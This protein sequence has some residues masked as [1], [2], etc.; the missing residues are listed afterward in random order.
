MNIREAEDRL[1][2]RWKS[3]YGDKSFVI[4][5][6][7]QPAIYLSQQRKVVFVLKDGNLG[8]ASE[9]DNIYDQRWELE[10]APTPWWATLARWCYFIAMPSATWQHALSDIRDSDAIRKALSA[11]CIIQLKKTWGGGSV[12][13]QSLD[14]CV[15]T[16]RDYI[17]SQ[18]SIYTPQFIIA[19]GNGDHLK[20]LFGAEIGD[21]K[22][23]ANGVGYW[24]VILN[25]AMCYLVDYCHPS[26]RVG[27]K[28][29]GLIAKGLIG[30]I[31]EIESLNAAE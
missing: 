15:A 16:D 24:R 30:A 6:C 11:H 14:E 25:G 1:F 10:N 26:I 17:I 13:A 19:C 29:K 8:D 9:D 2:A 21:R 5:G 3:S 27:T 4:D 7:P 31:S 18:L 23:T 20:G 12:S 28:V 22:W